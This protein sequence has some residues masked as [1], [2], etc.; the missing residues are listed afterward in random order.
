MSSKLDQYIDR[1][2]SGREEAKNEYVQQDQMVITSMQKAGQKFEKMF[3]IYSTVTVEKPKKKQST[4]H[5]KPEEFKD[6]ILVVLQNGP[7]PKGEVCDAMKHF[8][9]LNANDL[10][11]QSDNIPRFH[12][13]MD[14]MRD[15][16]VKE[17]ILKS[18]KNGQKGIWEF[19]DSHLDALTK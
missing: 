2:Q 17:G 15:I 1:Q 12:K 6:A 8:V 9:H 7:K 13:T 14:R 5:T 4:N 3:P 16:L 19:T 10:E 18:P 11:L